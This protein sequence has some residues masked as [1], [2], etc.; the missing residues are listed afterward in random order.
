[1][2]MDDELFRRVRDPLR[3]LTAVPPARLEELAGDEDFLA[4][5]RAMTED[6]DR[7][8]TERRW[9]QQRPQG[10]QAPAAIAYFS[11][12]F[13]VHE[14]LPNYSGGLGVLAGDHLKAAS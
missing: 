5:A 12:E 4:R 6:L 10:E 1:A 14:A 7:Y 3:M 8:L 9:Y 13:G 11:M 2:S